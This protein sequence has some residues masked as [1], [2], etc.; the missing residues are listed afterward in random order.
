M[1]TILQRNG[2]VV[3]TAKNGVEAL[4]RL[5]EYRYALML[6]DLMMPVMSGWTFVK[7]CRLIDGCGDLPIIAM[8]AMLNSQEAATRLQDLGVRAYLA[9]SQDRAWP[10]GSLLPNDL[11]VFDMLGNVYEWCQDGIDALRPAKKGFY[12]DVINRF[13]YVSEKDR[14]LLRGGSYDDRPANVRELQVSRRGR[15]RVLINRRRL[16]PARGRHGSFSDV[17]RKVRDLL[18]PAVFQ[19]LDFFGLQIGY[20]LAV[21]VG[22]DRINLDQVSRDADDVF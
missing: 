6:L 17:V 1:L 11:G 21:P 16:F 7:Q 22:D 9:S 8:S 13:E 14:R 20:D 10:S 18:L 5:G 15:G 12:S 4:E 19:D 2:M 3:D